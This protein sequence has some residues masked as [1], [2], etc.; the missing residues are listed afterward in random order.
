MQFSLLNDGSQYNG[1]FVSSDKEKNEIQFRNVYITGTPSLIPFMAVNT[2]QLSGTLTLF[3]GTATELEAQRQSAMRAAQ[4]SAQSTTSS[5]A[6]EFD[7]E[8]QNLKL[9]KWKEEEVTMLGCHLPTRSSFVF[10]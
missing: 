1:E 3:E 6:T 9:E 10:P 8:A 5:T 2:S 7:L 4:G